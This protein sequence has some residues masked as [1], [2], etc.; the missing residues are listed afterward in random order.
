KLR[1]DCYNPNTDMLTWKVENPNAQNHPFIYA[2]WWSSQRDTLFAPPGYSTFMTMNNP[3]SNSTW[4]DDNIT[5]I[6]WMD[7]TL[8]PGSP[9]SIVM[10]ARLS[11]T[12]SNARL[13]F[14]PQAEDAGGFYSGRLFKNVSFSKA[15]NE[16]FAEAHISI[17]PNPVRDEVSIDLGEMGCESQVRILNTMG[18][19]VKAEMM[20]LRQPQT[21]NLSELP[22]G[23][24]MI[25]IS[26][27][28]MNISRKLIKQ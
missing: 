21:L 27:G 16:T 26:S 15:V 8:T 24:Y 6:W 10:S 7:E 19:Q 22:A 20:D 11:R 23:V 13:E 28:G 17:G 18:Q 2:Q 4:G 9:Y 25:E 3:Q 5:G 14:T 1:F 12:C